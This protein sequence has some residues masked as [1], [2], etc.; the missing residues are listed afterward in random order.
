MRKMKKQI[1]I[2]VIIFAALQCFC[3]EKRFQPLRNN[4]SFSLDYSSTLQVFRKTDNSYDFYC[5]IETDWGMYQ[6]SKDKRQLLVFEYEEKMFYLLDGETGV[7]KPFIKKP[8]NART[9]FDFNYIIWEKEFDSSK[10]RSKMPVIVITS[11]KDD[12]DLFEISWEELNQDYKEDYSFGYHF[13]RS[14]EP[15][16]DFFVYAKGE[17]AG[18]YLGFMKINIANK[19]IKKFYR[20]E[21]PKQDY[22][23]ECYGLE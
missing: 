18:N 3:E 22:P 19:I 20:N 12:K 11:L 13:I 9:S 23:P 21:I 5:N 7:Y 8:L 15:E 14:N 6:L 10:D 17:G 2:L 16:Y 1:V 4:E